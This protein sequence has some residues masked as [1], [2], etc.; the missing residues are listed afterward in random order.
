MITIFSIQ[1]K[2]SQ[3]VAFW[4]ETPIDITDGFKSYTLTADELYS[5][6]ALF[7]NTKKEMEEDNGK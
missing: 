6:C 5:A 7:I 1:D 2:Q 4:D 3:A